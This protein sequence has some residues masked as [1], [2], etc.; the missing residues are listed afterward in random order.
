MHANAILKSLLLTMA[1]RMIPLLSGSRHIE[2][3][4]VEF[5][6]VQTRLPDV[7]ARLEDGRIFHLELQ[8]FNDPR[9]AKR[10]LRYWS[11]IEERYP[12]EEIGQMLLYV[13]NPAL[14]MT[15]EISRRGIHYEFGM[16][17]I[18]TM[19][20]EELLISENP[21][22]RALAILAAPDEPGRMARRILASWHAAPR[23]ERAQLIDT[24]MLI[25]GLRKLERVVEKEIQA[26]P[27]DI[28]VMEN[29]VIREWIEK[30]M[31]A[32]MHAGMQQGMQQGMHQGQGYLLKRLI[33]SKFGS[34]SPTNDLRI[35]G[36]SD[37]DLE[38]WSISL[39]TA[40]TIDAVFCG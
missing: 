1:N 38:Q 21:A 9:M 13:G 18:R 36:A 11:L 15:N 3:L 24:L 30:G 40:A 23:A 6:A 26:M 7:V 17:D 10:M 35:D 37:A 8:T 29:E 14:T 32:G 28:D 2:L 34:L 12:R 33:L 27:L 25:C 19:P 16:L 20:A 31:H 4:S 39:L 5:P 22:D